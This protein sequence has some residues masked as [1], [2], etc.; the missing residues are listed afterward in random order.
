MSTEQV[1]FGENAEFADNPEPRCPCLLLLDTSG[2][3]RGQ[4]IN[5]LN[6]GIRIFKDELSADQMAAKRVEVA[7]VGFGPAQVITDFQTAD[8]F[9]PPVLTAAG[10]TPIGAAIEMGLALLD[11]RKQVYRTN[12]VSYYRPWIFLL[13]DG[14]PTDYWKDAAEKIKAGEAAKHFSFFTVGVEGARMDI[15]S[16][17]ATRE[18]LKLKELRFRDLF[19]WLSSSLASVSKS[20]VGEQVPLQT[21]VSPSGWASV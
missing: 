20:S 19:V 8:I 11:Q 6:E 16:Q 10:D 13:T 3:M 15:L 17:I 4:P 5:Q 12:G 7:I 18:P 14:G 2:S 21:P 9:Q 1:P